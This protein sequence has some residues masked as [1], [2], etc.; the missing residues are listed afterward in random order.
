[1]HDN[2]FNE[3]LMYVKHP[4]FYPHDKITNSTNDYK[5]IIKLVIF[6]FVSFQYNS[7]NKISFVIISSLNFSIL[8][9][10]SWNRLQAIISSLSLKYNQ[11]SENFNQ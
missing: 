6:M 11:S 1:M 4:C 5:N 10:I 8:I 7:P 9:H 2:K 3:I